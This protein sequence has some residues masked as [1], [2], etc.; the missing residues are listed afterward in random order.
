M[1]T[2]P[3]GGSKRPKANSNKLTKKKSTSPRLPKAL[4]PRAFGNRGTALY[5]YIF[6]DRRN[7]SSDLQEAAP[8]GGSKRSLQEVS[9]LG[10]G[11]WSRLLEA[12]GEALLN[13]EKFCVEMLLKA[14]LH[15]FCSNLNK[16]CVWIFGYKRLTAQIRDTPFSSSES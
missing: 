12:L 6:C 11:S 13:G 4:T 8:R 14:R 16:I 2:A 3:R 1:G 15:C 5:F 10:A 9:P 7:E